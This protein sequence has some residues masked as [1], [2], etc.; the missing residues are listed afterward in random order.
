M[1]ELYTK[2]P[3]LGN[4][5]MGGQAR[6]QPGRYRLD[7]R[8]GLGA[9]TGILTCTNFLSL[10]RFAICLARSLSVANNTVAINV[11]R[12]IASLAYGGCQLDELVAQVVARGLQVSS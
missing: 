6:A 12:C 7:I 11:A 1:K 3:S 4:E 9:T 5:N 8:I 10:T 2:G